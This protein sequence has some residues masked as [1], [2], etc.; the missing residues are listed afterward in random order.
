[1]VG[2][3][4]DG[5]TVIAGGQAMAGRMSSEEYETSLPKD[6][7]NLQHPIVSTSESTS[8]NVAKEKLAI[9]ERLT[10]KMFSYE[11]ICFLIAI[12]FTAL[13]ALHSS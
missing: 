11:I 6:A 8:H 5:N 10:A 7:D 12:T 9:E 2:K 3:E 1:M 4:R 13:A